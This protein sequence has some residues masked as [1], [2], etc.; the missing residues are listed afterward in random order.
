MAANLEIESL[1]RLAVT[2]KKLD[3][4]K[5]RLTWPLIPNLSHPSVLVRPTQ[6][7]PLE[8]GHF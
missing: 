5:F 2:D 7:L 8:Y 1:S 3:E 4:K 6:P